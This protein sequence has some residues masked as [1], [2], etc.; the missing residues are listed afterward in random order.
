MVG[1]ASVEVG[2]QRDHNRYVSLGVPHRRNEQVEKVAPFGV[3]LALRVQLLE[4]VD[5]EHQRRVL[6]HR[7][8]EGPGSWVRERMRPRSHDDDARSNRDRRDET[9]SHQRGLPAS[10]C[11]DQGDAP[12]RADT[13]QEKGDDFLAAEEALVVL[14]LQTQSGYAHTTSAM[15][16]SDLPGSTTAKMR[17]GR[18]RP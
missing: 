13:L 15:S 14:G 2:A 7:M 1:A 9:R 6:G 8:L 11:A 12:S 5:H 18:S 10:R 3:V 16:R 4:L 17:S